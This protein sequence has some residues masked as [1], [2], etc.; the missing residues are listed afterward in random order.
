GTQPNGGEA[1]QLQAIDSG[2]MMTIVQS[3]PA[4]TVGG[5]GQGKTMAITIYHWTGNTPNALAP[6]PRTTVQATHIALM[7]AA[8]ATPGDAAL[9]S[10][11]SFHAFSDGGTGGD[12]CTTSKPSIL[13]RIKGIFQR[14]PFPTGRC[15]DACTPDKGPYPAEVTSGEQIAP[16]PVAAIPRAPR[17]LFTGL[18]QRSKS[19]DGAD[20]STSSELPKADKQK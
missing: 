7:P 3:R 5:S 9:Y 1:Y 4:T 12:C 8:G 16:T 20:T 13:E 19:V 14:N 15:L 2:E 10:P 18:S 11:G 17:R 6:V